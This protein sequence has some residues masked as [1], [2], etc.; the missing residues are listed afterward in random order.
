MNIKALRRRALIVSIVVLSM[1]AFLPDS[2]LAQESNKPAQEFDGIDVSQ[3]PDCPLRIV[4]RY[5]R[6]RGLYAYRMLNTG[7]KVIRGYVLVWDGDRPPNI[8]FAA[9]FSRDD[10][11]RP[12]TYQ[13]GEEMIEG[14]YVPND[15]VSSI[16]IDY[17]AFAD[18]S[19]WGPN[20]EQRSVGIDGAIE[21]RRAAISD[22]KDLATRND[23][24]EITRLLNITGDLAVKAPD[25][26]R[27][28]NWRRGYD[29]GY[30]GAVLWLAR[31]KD[32]GAEAIVTQLDTMKYALPL[33]VDD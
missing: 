12:G 13:W 9:I 2:L 21:G 26:T 6:G 5:S 25:A 19:S 14:N 30:W 20:K 31:Y 28:L 8:R 11:F 23:W 27:P 32:A 3:A 29:M 4:D 7:K 1:M 17:V 18:G 16:K 24:Y 15:G 33:A 22:L 10:L